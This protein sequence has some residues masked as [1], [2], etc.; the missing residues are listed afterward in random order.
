M[1]RSIYF[2]DTCHVVFILYDV[3]ELTIIIKYLYCLGLMLFH[4]LLILQKI[5]KNQYLMQTKTWKAINNFASRST[6]VLHSSNFA[7]INAI[8]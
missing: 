7:N 1:S 3:E 6:L 5:Y 2:V 4:L 8:V